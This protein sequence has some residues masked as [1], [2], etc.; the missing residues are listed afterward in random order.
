MRVALGAVHPIPGGATLS[1]T[2]TFE[3][4]AGGK[5]ACVANALYRIYE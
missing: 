4:A 5:P 3:P 2:L 1:L